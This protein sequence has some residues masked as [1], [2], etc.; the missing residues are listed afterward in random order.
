VNT[1]GERVFIVAGVHDAAAVV[2]AAADALELT[3]E[4]ASVVAGALAADDVPESDE[5][6]SG[7]QAVAP[8]ANAASAKA[9]VK[10]VRT[11]TA[12]LPV[13]GTIPPD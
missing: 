11:G 6:L 4:F 5:P 2:V 9:T 10:R 12:G 8:A 3:A 13:L 1:P 7:E